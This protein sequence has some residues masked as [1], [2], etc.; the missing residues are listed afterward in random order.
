MGLGSEPMPWRDRLPLALTL[1]LRD[2]RHGRD[3]LD[4]VAAHIAPAL[5]ARVRFETGTS[6]NLSNLMRRLTKHGPHADT[7]PCPI[8]FHYAEAA[9][10][11]TRSAAGGSVDVSTLLPLA[12]GT[13][14]ALRYGEGVRRA[15]DIDIARHLLL[16]TVPSN[17]WEDVKRVE[18]YVTQR[19][20]FAGPP[21]RRSIGVF[22]SGY[23]PDAANREE[24]IFAIRLGA[25]AGGWDAV[26]RSINSTNHVIRTLPLERASRLGVDHK[27]SPTGAVAGGPEGVR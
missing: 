3:D 22:F 12:D 10:P 13:L 15:L 7:E 9:V 5:S 24:K 1:T 4:E 2:N 18:E 14:R 8:T 19:L 23:R 27:V 11:I 20:E 16:V 25:V 17:S 6:E 21:D 26:Y